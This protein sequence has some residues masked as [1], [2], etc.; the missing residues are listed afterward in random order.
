M[1]VNVP[2][3]HPRFGEL[4][5]CVCW[6]QDDLSQRTGRLLRYSNLKGLTAVTFEGLNPRGNSI[7]EDRQQLFNAAFESS[8]NFAEALEGWFILA[9]PSGSGKTA[10]AAAIANRVIERGM[11]VL[12]M[13]IPD[14]LDYLRHSYGNSTE[15]SYDYIYQQVRDAPLLVLDGLGLQAT[16]MWAQEKLFQVLNHRYNVGLPTV[17]TVSGPLTDLDDLLYTRINDVTLSRVVWLGPL[18]QS[19]SRLVGLPPQ[20]LLDE[21]TLK[22]FYVEGAEGTTASQQ[23]TLE[24]AYYATRSFAGDPRNHWLVISGSTG[25]GKTHLAVAVVNHRLNTGAAVFYTT[26]L[27]LLD[28]LRSAYAPG[29]RM[30]YDERFEHLRSV[31]LL[32][33][34]DFGSQ[35]STSWAEE[36]LY[37]LLVHRHDSR[38][39]TMITMDSAV[40]LRPAVLSRLRDQRFVT[41]IPVRAPDYREIGRMAPRY[42]EEELK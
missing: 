22:S 13:V 6:D 15:E 25:V 10:L 20:P 40:E 2:V 11:A 16:T 42:V 4:D 12:F 3:G 1:R 33:L 35:S 39:P 37:Q 29:S 32:V 38:L 23:D 26:V 14:L 27:D 5:P 8:M 24:A 17:L 34:D 18:D 21:M 30:S 19:S 36:K 41:E 9:G 7:D 28:H 31:P